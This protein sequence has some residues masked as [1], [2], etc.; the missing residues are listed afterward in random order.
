[1]C[2]DD[3]VT[4]DFDDSLR[5]GWGSWSNFPYSTNAVGTDWKGRHQYVQI[6]I[7]NA[8]SNNIIGF[9][10]G[11]T[12][13]PAYYTTQVA[14]NMYLQGGT[15]TSKSDY[16]MTATPSTEWK[17]YTYDCFVVCSLASGKVHNSSTAD[18]YTQVSD[19]KTRGSVPGNAWHYASSEEV[20]AIR[21][22]LLG[23]LANYNDNIAKTSDTRKNIKAGDH[24]EVDY[25]IFGSSRDQLDSWTS[26]LED[27]A[28]A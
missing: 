2:F 27:S 25:I 28:N 24:V 13:S 12:S 23:A 16:A 1:M 11:R 10:F 17:T 19:I 4:Y 22:H 5:P 7:L 21:F 3:I 26:Y 9:Q 6:R 18:Y 15:P 8:S 20:V 14:S